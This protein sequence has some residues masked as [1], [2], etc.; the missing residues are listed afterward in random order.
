MF[1][2]YE[3]DPIRSKFRYAAEAA[4][5]KTRVDHQSIAEGLMGG[6]VCRVDVQPCLPSNP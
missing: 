6:L 3:Y 5:D 4:D 2:S 1:E